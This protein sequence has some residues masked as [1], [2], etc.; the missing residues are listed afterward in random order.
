MV[1]DFNESFSI[2]EIWKQAISVW[3]LKT[4]GS[5]ALKFLQPF[6]YRKADPFQGPG[7]GSCLMLRNESPEETPALTK[8]ETLLGRD[9][10]ARSSRV[11]E[12]RTALPYGSQSQVLW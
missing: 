4:S 12:P 6:C 2:K 9:I 7:V 3:W 5:M 1:G 11:R 10:W 8:Q